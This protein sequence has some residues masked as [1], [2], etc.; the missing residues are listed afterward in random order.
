MENILHDAVGILKYYTRTINL[1][2]D[3]NIA[4]YYRSLLPKALYIK[5]PRTQSHISVVRPFE[6]PNMAL[7]G[8][9]ENERIP[10]KYWLPIYTD[11]IYCWLDC[12]SRRLEEIRIELGLE[13][14]RIGGVFHITVGNFK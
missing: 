7:W 5:P 1:V 13:A 14:H 10:I 4:S 12:S 8:K 2:L 11:G 6:E 9:Y 3:P